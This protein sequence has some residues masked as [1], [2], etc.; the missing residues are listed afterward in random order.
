[1]ESL[2]HE[3]K[4]FSIVAAFL[5]YAIFNFLAAQE[6]TEWENPEV[7]R[8]NVEV[9]RASFYHYNSNDLNTPTEERKNYQSLNGIWKF[10]WSSK[11][12][13]RRFP[14][15]KT[16]YKVSDWDEIDVPSD[17]QMRGFGY[18]IY[19]NLIYPFQKIRF[20]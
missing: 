16:D 18:P 9:P 20:G 17:W 4:K 10:K 11:P 1:M 14:F 6:L 7:I 3:M 15:H 8:L 5:S 12:V 13:E 2:T 19:T